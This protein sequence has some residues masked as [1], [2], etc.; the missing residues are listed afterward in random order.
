ML[1]LVFAAYS[2]LALPVRVCV[3]FFLGTMGAAVTVQLR[4]LGVCVGFETGV[5][6]GKKRGEKRS[7]AWISML[8][9]AARIGSLDANARVGT[10]D[11]MHT[12]LA[13]GA[14]QSA[15]LAAL[16]ALGAR[17]DAHV[18]VTPDFAAPCLALH[19][20][21]IFSVTAGDIILSA[22][23]SARRKKR[24]EGLRWSSIPSRT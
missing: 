4:A 13:A 8:R 2:F 23:A 24:K 3:Q 12:A 20:S 10:G 21:C 7:R 16:C 14:L 1:F 15:L 17:Q 9:R 18:R 6:P 19:A 11:A 5:H 22:A